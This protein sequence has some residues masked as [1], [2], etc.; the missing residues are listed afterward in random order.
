MNVLSDFISEQ[1]N[2]NEKRKELIESIPTP[3]LLI[4]SKGIII[5][6]NAMFNHYIGFDDN[7]ILGK[8][9]DFFIPRRLHRLC[10]RAMKELVDDTYKNKKQLFQFER[11]E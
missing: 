9:Y 8:K 10:I 2:S 6:C 11:Q 5:Q 3:S 7:E 1:L 4:D